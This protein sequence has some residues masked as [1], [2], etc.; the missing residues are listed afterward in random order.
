MSSLLVFDSTCGTLLVAPCQDFNSPTALTSL[1][2]GDHVAMDGNGL[3]PSVEGGQSVSTPSVVGMSPR[4]NH[5]VSASE[6][7]CL[8]FTEPEPVLG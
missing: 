2:G 7:N 8:R 1:S 6:S 3:V 5:L 4:T